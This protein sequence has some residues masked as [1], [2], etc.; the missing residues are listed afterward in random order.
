MRSAEL[1]LSGYRHWVERHIKSLSDQA[2]LGAALNDA[3]L[4]SN[5]RSNIRQHSFTDHP[6]RI[7]R[8]ILDSQNNLRKSG[9]LK[10]PETLDMPVDVARVA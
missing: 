3:G 8:I 7:G 9:S 10:F 1:W 4:T 5:F 2:R 6:D